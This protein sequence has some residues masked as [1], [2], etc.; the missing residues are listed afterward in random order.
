MTK[1]FEG[2]VSEALRRLTPI[3]SHK[4]PDHP[5][6][7]PD[8]VDFL[9]CFRGGFGALEAKEVT[10]RDECDVSI[11]TANQRAC[12]TRVDEA[13]G[14]AALVVNFDRKRGVGGHVGFTFAWKYP[15]I[16]EIGGRLSIY[17]P[18]AILIPRVAGGWAIDEWIR[19]TM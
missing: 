4:C 17:D 1:V 12:L 15:D 13:N 10:N 8:K 19:R 3:Y 11:L 18:N 5:H 6:A 7:I 14:F 16:P 9:F 2:E